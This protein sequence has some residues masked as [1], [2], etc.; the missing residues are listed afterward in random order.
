M[1]TDQRIIVP[2]ALAPVVSTDI[3]DLYDTD[4]D[5]RGTIPFAV[6]W[7]TAPNVGETVLN[8]PGDTTL[9]AALATSGGATINVAAGSYGSLNIAQDDQHWILA[10]AA[11]FSGMNVSGESRI[12]IE[13]GAVTNT[14][15]FCNFRGEDILVRNVNFDITEM[16]MGIGANPRSSR[17]AFVHNTI[18]AADYTMYVDE[19]LR[20]TGGDLGSHSDFI[21]AANDMV[22]GT[23]STQSSCRIQAV[24]RGIFVD[25]RTGNDDGWCWRFHHGDGPAWFRR[26]MVDNGSL[27]MNLYPDSGQSAPDSADNFAEFYCY[28]NEFYLSSSGPYVQR[29]DLSYWGTLYAEDNDGYGGNG[30]W[31]FNS[32]EGDVISGN[33]NGGT[34]TPPALGSWLAAGGVQPGA[35]H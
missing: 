8:V 1:A 27:G 31:A 30:A 3:Y 11:N 23:G 4:V 33:S 22:G 17:I 28:D 14:G 20:S 16:S 34:T 18:S 7:P 29:A 15:A 5:S 32:Q 12:I 21:M 24:A 13:G 19:G 2:T 25:N 26:N 6:N 9:S 35:D 10:D